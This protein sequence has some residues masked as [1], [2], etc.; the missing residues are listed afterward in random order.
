MADDEAP[1]SNLLE[2][3]GGKAALDE[4]VADF[5]RRVTT[6]PELAP[7]FAGVD[8][9]RLMHMQDE[10]LAAAFGGTDHTAGVDLR[11]AHA[12]RHI[13]PHQFSRFVEHFLDTLAA[14]DLPRATMDQATGRLALYVDDVVGEYGASG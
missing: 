12:G 4:I 6:D 2:A 11:A 9:E 14:R 5:Y 3:L 1:R 7:E 10:F 13:T 8:V